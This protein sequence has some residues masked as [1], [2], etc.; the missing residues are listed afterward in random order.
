MSETD[1]PKRRTNK[2]KVVRA[3]SKPRAQRSGGPD[4]GGGD[5]PVWRATPE[6]KKKARTFRIVAAVA[7]VIAIALEVVAIVKWLDGD[8]FGLLIGALVVIAIFAIGGSL[9][10]KKANDLDPA[11]RKDPIRFFV[12]NQ[13]GAIISVIAFLPLIVLILLNKDMDKQQKAIA[14]GI[15]A[16]LLVVAVLLGADFSP[17]SVEKKTAE[18]QWDQQ[19]VIALT[20]QDEVYWVDTGSVYHLCAEVSALQVTSTADEIKV[21]TVQDAID[22]GMGRLTK[23]VQQEINQCGLPQPDDRYLANDPPADLDELPADDT[24]DDQSDDT[25]DAGDTDDGD[26]VTTTTAAD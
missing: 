7:W 18:A 8:H 15:G 10:W 24:G 9:L 6:A 20:G 13:L 1:K 25:G 23:Q 26:L 4:G 5:A 22:G 2:K 3:E 14:G 12:Q 19:R 16:V 21:G 11:S 17:E